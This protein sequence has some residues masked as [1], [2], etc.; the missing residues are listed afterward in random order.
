[1]ASK[2]EGFLKSLQ[3]TTKK[4]TALKCICERRGGYIDIDVNRE[5]AVSIIDCRRVRCFY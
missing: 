1:M 2:W 3:K 4:R 5:T